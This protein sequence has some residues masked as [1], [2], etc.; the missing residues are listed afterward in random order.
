MSVNSSIQT[1][2]F[3][4]RS[5][6]GWTFEVDDLRFYHLSSVLRYIRA[7]LDCPLS[8]AMTYVR[9]IGYYY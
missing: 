8:D 5:D 7:A 9:S 6:E 2:D 1:I 4:I 3:A